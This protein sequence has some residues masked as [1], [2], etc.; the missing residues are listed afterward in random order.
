MPF[1]N[2][3]RLSL[4]ASSLLSYCLP[5]YAANV[6]PI[7]RSSLSEALESFALRIRHLGAGRMVGMAVCLPFIV[8]LVFFFFLPPPSPT[9]SSSLFFSSAHLCIVY[10]VLLGVPFSATV[11]IKQGVP[12]AW[13]PSLGVDRPTSNTS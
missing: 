12:A 13:V 8:S 2:T 1:N 6:H 3:K 11:F 4:C 9:P 7:A 5:C 10:T